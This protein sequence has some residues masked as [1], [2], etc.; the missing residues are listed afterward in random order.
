MAGVAEKVYNLLKEPIEQTGIT[1]WDVKFLKEGA[2]WFLRVY[3]DKEGGIGIDECTD[4]SHLIDPIIDEADPIDKSYYLEVCSCGLGRELTRDWH[5]EKMLGKA[6]IVK[7]YTAYNG[8]KQVGGTL[9]SFDGGVLVETANGE[10][11]FEKKDFSAVVLDDI[12]F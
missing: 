10:V 6:I 5:F 7:L 4:V 12:D 2:S 3:I 1:L 8:E 9:K 11:Y